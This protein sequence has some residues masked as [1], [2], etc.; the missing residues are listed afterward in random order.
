MHLDS[1]IQ[2][3]ARHATVG[4]ALFSFS[5]RLT[6]QDSGTWPLFLRFP[7][8]RQREASALFTYVTLNV[9]PGSPSNSFF[10]PM[11]LLITCSH[12]AIACSTIYQQTL[13]VSCMLLC[14]YSATACTTVCTTPAFASWTLHLRLHAPLFLVRLTACCL[15][16]QKVHLPQAQLV[17]SVGAPD[18]AHGRFQ[19]R[20][21][22]TSLLFKSHSYL[23]PTLPSTPSSRLVSAQHRHTCN[24]GKRHRKSLIH[25]LR[26]LRHSWWQIWKTIGRWWTWARRS[27]QT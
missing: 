16:Q 18:L 17:L 5:Q 21:F 13:F 15:L 23:A 4:R 1:V 22:L 6:K 20:R 14:K 11:S 7:H 9:C 10:S 26:C 8:L 24:S 19:S 12:A 27:Q 2:N 3:S 25:T